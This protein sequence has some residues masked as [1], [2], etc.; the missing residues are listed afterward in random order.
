MAR[1]EEGSGPCLKPTMW[2]IEMRSCCLNQNCI[3]IFSNVGCTGALSLPRLPAR[4]GPLWPAQVRAGAGRRLPGLEGEAP[5]KAGAR[6]ALPTVSSIQGAHSQE[7]V[8]R[9]RW[10]SGPPQARAGQDGPEA[11][12]PRPLTGLGLS[13]EGQGC[14]SG[15]TR[16]RGR[17]VEG[18]VLE[19]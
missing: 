8:R 6:A 19:L 18:C 10:A 2:Q 9:S 3:P 11:A 15:C 5:G 13:P 17:R 1:R 14:I 12:P 4:G 16:R 7:R